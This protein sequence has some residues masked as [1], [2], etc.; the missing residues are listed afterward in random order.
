MIER[1]SFASFS[2][3]CKC[4]SS[5]ASQ[6]C[7]SCARVAVPCRDRAHRN[8]MK[9][10]EANMERKA[11]QATSPNIDIDRLLED[12]AQRLCGVVWIRQPPPKPLRAAPGAAPEPAALRRSSRGSPPT[13][14]C[15]ASPRASCRSCRKALRDAGRR[16][17]GRLLP[18]WLR[19]RTGSKL[20]RHDGLR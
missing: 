2:W 8:V 6:P 10:F 9:G 13:R 3:T 18:S 5:T 17:G 16:G 7:V 15:A 20:R 1:D 11:F 12:C 19:S 4:P 14:G